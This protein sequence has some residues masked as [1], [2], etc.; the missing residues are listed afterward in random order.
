MQRIRF[1]YCRKEEVKYISHL[2]IMRTLHR[3][4]RRAG[5]SLVYRGKYNPQPRLDPGIP[6][7]LGVTSEQEYGE[8][9]LQRELSPAEFRE[10]VNRQ[11]PPGLAISR[12]LT[13]P[14][15]EPSLMEQL[16]CAL[17]LAHI[18]G[19][20][21][22]GGPG[23]LLEK[24]LKTVEASGEITVQRKGKKKKGKRRERVVNIR[25]FLYWLKAEDAPGGAVIKM[26]LQTGNRGGASPGEVLEAVRKAV[27]Y[28]EEINLKGIHRAGLYRFDGRELKAPPPFESG[29]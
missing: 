26:L 24:A 8:V 15:K 28:P 22:R 25:P 11:L 23:E 13:V 27:P 7:P 20:N 14:R 16:N 4:F 1:S 18:A 21:G 17:Y 2:D 29:D 3:A 12:A 5:L 6:L 19:S 10:S 9:Y